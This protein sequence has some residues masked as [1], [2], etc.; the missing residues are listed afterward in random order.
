MLLD[1]LSTSVK[2]ILIVTVGSVLVCYIYIVK[3]YGFR[4]LNDIVFIKI[5]IAL[6]TSIL[7]VLLI[8]FSY[9][10]IELDKFSNN[11]AL[12]IART[13]E[14][15]ISESRLTLED[16]RTN[17]ETEKHLKSEDSET[18]NKT[19]STSPTKISEADFS[20]DGVQLFTN[21]NEVTNVKKVEPRVENGIYG[22]L[23]FYGNDLQVTV[24]KST[25]EISNVYLLTNKT[26]TNRGVRV[27]DY[28]EKIV[29]RYGQPDDI[30]Y[31]IPDIDN[32]FAYEYFFTNKDMRGILRFVIDK[33]TKK[34][35]YIGA[36]AKNKLI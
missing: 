27:G 11:N 24:S 35:I 12:N 1:I 5:I 9:S 23:Y 3:K 6:G 22:T 30:L 34:I 13:N 33:T 20:L 10:N 28:A 2:G 18:N 4:V 29:S 8:F 16:S 7:S 15:S 32:C 25:N 36:G 21:I 19:I 14:I 26:S 31:N 17:K